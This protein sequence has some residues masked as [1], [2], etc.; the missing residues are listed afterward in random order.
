MGRRPDSHGA[1]FLYS[2]PHAD[3]RP[4]W[5]QRLLVS[6]PEIV[7]D[8]QRQFAI[9]EFRRGNEHIYKLYELAYD[10]D[11][12]KSPNTRTCPYYAPFR[13]AAS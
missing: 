12:L 6:R 13:L 2:T 3:Y 7:A 5:Y 10:P 9:C 1:R 8:V 11:T 4:K